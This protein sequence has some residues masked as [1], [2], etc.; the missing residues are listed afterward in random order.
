MSRELK[1]LLEEVRRNPVHLQ[2]LR[3]LVHD[4]E[5]VVR[6][7]VARGFA[8]TAQEAAE[9]FATEWEPDDD[10]LEQVAG[11]EDG[12]GSTPPPPPPG[13]GS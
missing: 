9:L 1:H 7:A 11:G 5:A 6:W 3:S 12:W 2:E 13:D 8:L 10:V 4:P